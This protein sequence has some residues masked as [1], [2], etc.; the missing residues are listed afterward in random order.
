[1]AL[2]IPGAR[3]YSSEI[4]SAISH[5]TGPPRPIVSDIYDGDSLLDA[6]VYSKMLIDSRDRRGSCFEFLI[7]AFKKSFHYSDEFGHSM[8]TMSLTNT[9]SLSLVLKTKIVLHFPQSIPFPNLEA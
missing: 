4:Y 7:N 8:P 1:M 5:V 9:F 6:F 3:L 2:V